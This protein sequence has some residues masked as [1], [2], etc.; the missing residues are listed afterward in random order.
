[1]NDETMTFSVVE[2]KEKEIKKNLTIIY[3]ALVQRVII[4]L[5]RLSV[6]F[7]QK[8]QHT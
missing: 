7:F 1:M 6:I 5:I 8:T 4:L 3:D 2:E